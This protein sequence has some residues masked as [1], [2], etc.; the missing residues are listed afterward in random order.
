MA[1]LIESA[2]FYSTSK[3]NLLSEEH[4]V[5]VRTLISS[6]Y[7]AAAAAVMMVVVISTIIILLLLIML[8]LLLIPRD[9]Q[10]DAVVTRVFSAGAVIPAEALAVV[11]RPVD[12]D[13]EMRAVRRRLREGTTRIPAIGGALGVSHGI[14]LAAVAPSC[15]YDWVCEIMRH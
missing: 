15:S 11:L 10:S 4:D 12:C 1:L 3:Y 6:E 5:A 13:E 7:A 2:H 8:M 9:E 14:V